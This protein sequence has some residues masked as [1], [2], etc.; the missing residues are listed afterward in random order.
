[1]KLED[2]KVGDVVRRPLRTGLPEYTLTHVTAV[3]DSYFE[4][5]GSNYPF[6]MGDFAEGLGWPTLL[7][8]ASYRLSYLNE[9]YA[10]AQER[11]QWWDE[12][13]TALLV[14]SGPAA[15]PGDANRIEECFRQLVAEHKI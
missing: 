3:C 15:G 8:A 4:I 5:N 6:D 10:I 11:R 9:A 2:I 14:A 12:L 1:M 7:E 13:M